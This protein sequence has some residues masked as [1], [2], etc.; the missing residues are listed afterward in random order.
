MALGARRRAVV[1]MVLNRGFVYAI[2]GISIGLAV[3][4]GVT[5]WMAGALF[6]VHATD[7]TTLTAVSL[8]LLLVA[9]AACWLPARRAAAIDP[10]EALRAE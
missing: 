4:V 10:V 9:L 1:A 2:L 5:R 7:P 6:E 3:S 8:L